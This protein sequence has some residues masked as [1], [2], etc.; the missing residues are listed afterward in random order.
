MPEKWTLSRELDSFRQELNGLLE[1]LGRGPD[2][3]DKRKKAPDGEATKAIN[4]LLE[5]HGL[6]DLFR[7]WGTM[8]GSP[9]IDSVGEDSRYTA[10][11]DL[12]GVDPNKTAIEVTGDLVTIKGYRY[13]YGKSRDANCFRREIRHGAFERSIRLPEGVRADDLRAIYQDGVL[14]LSAPRTMK[15]KTVRIQIE[16]LEADAEKEE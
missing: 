4:D 3:F 10:R 13:G 2:F 9:P 8:K 5:I 14:A 7:P 1:R 11:I 15:T 12:P 6:A 16:G